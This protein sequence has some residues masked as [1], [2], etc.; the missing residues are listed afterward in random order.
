MIAMQ[1]N[2]SGKMEEPK[3]TKMEGKNGTQITTYLFHLQFSLRK[4]SA[5]GGKGNER[6]RRKTHFM[7][8]SMEATAFFNSRI[9]FSW[10]A[11]FSLF[12]VRTSSGTFAS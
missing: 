5:Q 7:A 8:L 3:T 4:S 2:T 1:Q 11:N 6:T 12:I 9:S 10:L